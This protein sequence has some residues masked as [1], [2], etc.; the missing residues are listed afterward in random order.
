MVALVV[1]CYNEAD[2][3]KP[4]R[5]ADALRS[6]AALHLTFVDD[7]SRDHTRT[8]L[9]TLAGRC[10]ERAS[11]LALPSNVGKAEAVRRGLN[12]VIADG[13]EFVGYW[14]ADLA[15]PLD[16]LPDFMRVF[17]IRPN[18][19]IVLG[20]RVRLLGRDIERSTVRHF[21]GRVFATL[22]SVVLDIPVYDTQC[23]AKVLRTNTR[24]ERILSVPFSSR[25]IFDVELL[26]RYLDDRTHPGEPDPS[27]QRI[28]ELALRSWIDEPGSKVRAKDGLRAFADLLRIYRARRAASVT[29]ASS[30][31]STT[32]SPVEAA[33]PSNARTDRSS[34]T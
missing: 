30:P 9:E 29:L 3:L 6:N 5:F 28:Y 17:Q 33:A 14:D 2:R 22:A 12:R 16:A 1:P 15:T 8:V 18:T 25:W 10:G 21:T 34:L 19:D 7:G 27:V 32:A 13:A 31:R 4:E 20:S 26:A 24:L 11:V 23:G